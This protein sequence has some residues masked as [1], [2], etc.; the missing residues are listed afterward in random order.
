MQ[1]EGPWNKQDFSMARSGHSDK[2]FNNP[3]SSLLPPC[4]FFLPFS[5]SLFTFICLLLPSVRTSFSWSLY[6]LPPTPWQMIVTQTLDFRIRFMC[7]F[8]LS[9]CQV[10]EMICLG[11]GDLITV[12]RSGKAGTNHH[13]CGKRWKAKSTLPKLQ[14]RCSP[15]PSG[16]I[17]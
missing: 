2:V 16:D 3:S 4:I 11:H 8:Q 6:P 15:Q 10:L 14:G 7:S 13:H 1:L 5:L 9:T 12:V 17:Y